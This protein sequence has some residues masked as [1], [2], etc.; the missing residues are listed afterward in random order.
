MKP[1]WTGEKITFL[2]DGDHMDKMAAMPIY[3]KNPSKF[4]FP[5]PPGHGQFGHLFTGPIEAKLLMELL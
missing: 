5:E 2:R 4:S 1:S 3:G